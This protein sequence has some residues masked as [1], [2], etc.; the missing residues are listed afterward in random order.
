MVLDH[1][2]NIWIISETGDLDLFDPAHETFINV[3]RQAFYQQQLGTVALESIYF[4]SRNRLWLCIRGQ[5]LALVDIAKKQIRRYRKQIGHSSTLGSDSVRAIIEDRTNRNHLWIATYWGLD[6]LDRRTGQFTH[7]RHQATPTSLPENLV[8]DLHQLPDGTILARSVRHVSLFDPQ[9]GIVRE[10]YPLPVQEAWWNWTPLVASQVPNILLSNATLLLQYSKNKGV[11]EFVRLPQGLQAQSL[12]IDRSDVLWVGTNGGGIL[13]YNLKASAFTA[14][15]YQHSFYADLLIREL[16]VSADRIPKLPADW[17][18]LFRSTTDSSG[19]IWFNIRTSPFYQFDP[20]TRQ[21]NAIPFPIHLSPVSSNL[22][23]PMATDPAG[24]IWAV[25]DSVALWYDNNQHQWIRFKHQLSEV[26]AHTE[27]ENIVVDRQALWLATRS[28]GLYRVDRISGQ[29]RQYAHKPNEASSLS[30]NNLFCLFADPANPAILWIGTFGSGLCRFDKR[31][32]M[33]QRLTTANGLPNNVI[34]AAIPDR[35]GALWIATNQGL[36]R[37]DRRTLRTRIYTREDGLAG[38][39]FNRQHLLQHPNG[40]IYLG[41]LE[42]ITSFNPGNLREDTYP[43]P[44]QIT[45]V[46]INNQPMGP[47]AAP[48]QTLADLTLPYDKNFVTVQFAAMQYNRRNKLRYRYQLEGLEKNWT[49]TDRP[50]VVYT[51]L[52]PGHYTLRL[53]AANTSDVWSP[54]IRTLS[55]T[56]KPPFWDTWWAYILYMLAGSGIV[57]GLVRAS[58]QR[59]KLQQ[60]MLL[61]QR[62]VELKHQEAEQLRATNEMKTRFFTNITHEFRTPLTLILAP[63]EQ[64]VRE[65]PDPRNRKRLVTIEQNAHQLLRLINQLLDLSKLEAS[66]MPVHE[67]RDDITECLSRWL[68]PLTEQAIVQGLELTIQS[69]VSGTYC[70]DAEKLERIVYNLT[71]NALNFTKSGSITVSVNSIDTGI[72]LSIADTGIGISAQDL[73][74][75]FDRFYQANQDYTI[76]PVYPGTGIGLALVKELVLLQKGTIN[77]ESTLNKGTTFTVEL[78]YQKAEPQ[79]ENS[80][81]L[82]ADSWGTSED[83]ERPRILIVEDKIELAHLIAES[84]PTTYRIR[85]AV[86]G[87][88][89]LELATEQ[90]PDLVISD[91]MMPQMDGFTLCSKL[92]TDLRT[93]HIP[94]ILLTA[95][96]SAENRMEGL[97]YGADDYLTKPFQMQ[98][99][100]LRVHNL[101]T[102]RRRLRDWIRT[103]LTTVEGQSA[104]PTPEQMDPFLDRLYEL[105]EM[106]L[107]DT[108][109]GVDRMMVELGMSR[110]NLFRK[111]KALTD[112]SANDLLRQYRLKR[113]TQLLRAG[114]PVTDTAYQ[115]GFDSPAYFT[116]CFRETYQLTPREFAAQA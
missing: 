14:T 95:K 65:N 28:K 79:V 96:V 25:Y 92:K 60:S 12:F 58:I 40:R 27:I 61:K 84:L 13:K 81:L 72:R 23:V 39:E 112:L 94:V 31:T 53:N 48:A 46:Q 19:K 47:D 29:V 103:S 116:K 45:S 1:Q 16:G 55:L 63:A 85:R 64:M 34:Y 50:I 87:R 62:E 9:L 99:L 102:S 24:H 59:G 43:T 88:D 68:H 89:G 114:Y 11:T 37:M 32:G 15:P 75:I 70:F 44:V 83:L 4:D 110:T 38:N 57:L 8:K 36:G 76:T 17:S 109:F 90:L 77:A 106:N 69:E 80:D 49:E 100:Q 104:Q 2:G 107:G 74:H 86:N 105:M 111:V 6:R 42:G 21:L 41:G 52:Q 78:P 97:S 101:L 115:V 71:A 73:P 82:V 56:I 30:T 67:S 54:N 66:V 20:S 26:S 3:S 51:G 93:S 10:T 22:P 98:E 5:G 33:C 7:Y 35:Q 113:A 108:E 91:V 18:Y